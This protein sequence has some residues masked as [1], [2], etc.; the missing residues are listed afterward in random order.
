MAKLHDYYKD[1]V[2]NK[3]MTEFNY[4]SV[5]QVPRV[6]KI[7]LNMGLSEAVADKKIIEHATG[8][9]TKI[10]GQKPVVTKSKK[11]I[12]GFKN[13]DLYLDRYEGWYSVRDEAYYAEDETTV[14]EDGTRVATDTGTE[15]FDQVV[16]ACH[17][18]QA[19]R[20]LARRGLP[21]PASH[22]NRDWTL[23]YEQSDQVEAAWLEVYR[24]PDQH[25]DLYQLGEKLTDIEDAFRLWRFRH[26]TTVE[27][28]IGFKR[29]TG[30]TGAPRRARPGARHHRARRES[31]GGSGP[32]RRRATRGPHSAH[33]ARAPGAHGAHGPRG[34]PL[35]LRAAPGLGQR[36]DVRLGAGRE[37]G[38][39]P[40]GQHEGPPCSTRAVRMDRSSSSATRPRCA[41]SRTPSSR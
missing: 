22:L 28:V 20:L 24:H 19:L 8:D 3:L 11:A 6:E 34:Q 31:P 18:D 33:P 39:P 4:N 32:H 25:W 29:G 14:T 30:G 36:V 35:R 17:S 10:A 26:V 38:A 41:P 27:R 13:G 12:A 15:G 23:P 2:V 16:L 40:G 37:G 9:L 1:E 5:M 21:V 7:T